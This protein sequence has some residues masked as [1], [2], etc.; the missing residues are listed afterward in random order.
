MSHLAAIVERLYASHSQ[1]DGVSI[2]PMRRKCC[3]DQPVRNSLDRLE[4]VDRSRWVRERRG[5]I[6]WPCIGLKEQEGKPCKYEC[7]CPTACISFRPQLAFPVKAA[8]FDCWKS[9]CAAFPRP[10][11]TNLLLALHLNGWQQSMS[12]S[13][14]SKGNNGSNPDISADPAS[15]PSRGGPQRDSKSGSIYSSAPISARAR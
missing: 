1:S 10:Q 9:V 6:H 2:V 7:G 12:E 5:G 14:M 4:R 11:T 15:R 13:L 8:S 3:S